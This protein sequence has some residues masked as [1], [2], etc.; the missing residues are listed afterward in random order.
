MTMPGVSGSG[1]DEPGVNGQGSSGDPVLILLQQQLK[2]LEADNLAIMVEMRAGNIRP[3]ILALLESKMDCLLESIGEVMGPQG[4]YFV[5]R[6]NIRWQQKLKEQLASIMK[7][8]RK[9]ALG[10]GAMLSPAQINELARETG[11]P[12]W[13]RG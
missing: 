8:G 1:T 4:P 3:D 2:E 9:A 11:T 6:A 13:K 10:L 5:M 12:G 7:E